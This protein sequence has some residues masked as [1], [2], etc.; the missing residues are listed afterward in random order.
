VTTAPYS[1]TIPQAPPGYY[2]ITA[3][4]TDNNN[5]SVNSTPITVTVQQP[6]NANAKKILFIV[7]T[8][9]PNASNVAEANHLF[10]LGYD[11][12]V[13]GAAGSVTADADGK[14]AVIISST[15]SSGDVGNKFV[16]SATPVMFWENALEDN[17]L[18]TL[19]TGTPTPHNSTGGL[20]TLDID[21]GAVG[22]KMAAGLSG[23]VTVT[24]AADTFAW[25]LPAPSAK[26]IATIT[27]SNPTEAAIYSVE[28][29]DTL[30]DGTSKAA[31]RRV[32][33]FLTDSTFLVLNADGVKLFDAA[34]DYTVNGAGTGPQPAKLSVSESNGNITITWTNGGTLYSAPAVTGPWTSTGNSTGTF[35]G[36]ATTGNQFFEVR[37]P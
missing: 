7:A 11:V 12:T 17:F 34:V 10:A 22:S 25:G 18:L 37:N 23:T 16:A 32:F 30:I 33:F 8:A 14:A 19:D 28:A 21:P 15:V 35:T 24:T 2:T 1:L 3:T 36:S 13:E 20:T 31:G 26:I 9:G 6:A 27:G 5:V 4:V 29:G